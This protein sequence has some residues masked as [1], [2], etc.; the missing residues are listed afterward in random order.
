MAG[1]LHRD[2][3]SWYHKQ[4]WDWRFTCVDQQHHAHEGKMDAIQEDGLFHC[5]NGM[6]LQ[7]PIRSVLAPSVE[8]HN[9]RTS[10]I[11]R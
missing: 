8:N 6:I 9:T 1:H 4:T 3:Q 7:K 2:S 5:P 10:A 11:V